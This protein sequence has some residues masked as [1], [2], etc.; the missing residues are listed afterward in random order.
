MILFIGLVVVLV[1]ISF[2]STQ[3]NELEGDL[4]Q[5]GDLEISQNIQ[6]TYALNAN[7]VAKLGQ[8]C[9][10]AKKNEVTD[11]M[12]YAIHLQEP[13]PTDTDIEDS[14]DAIEDYAT[15]DVS[16]CTSGKSMIIEYQIPKNIIITCS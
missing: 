13:V 8:K 10:Q 3:L 15:L 14:W 11:S 12:C 5:F 4:Q 1:V 6:E 16:G 2:A 9:Y 7:Q